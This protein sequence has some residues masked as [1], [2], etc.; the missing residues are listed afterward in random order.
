MIDLEPEQRETIHALL[1]TETGQK[2]LGDSYNHGW[3]DEAIDLAVASINEYL[4]LHRTT[5]NFNDFFDLCLEGTYV[6]YN[7]YGDVNCWFD[8]V[9]DVVMSSGS[10]FKTKEN[11]TRSD[12]LK[13]IKLK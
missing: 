6:F 5:I 8:K 4:A 3:V 9:Y 11:T 10:I 12:E 2:Y 13:F 1:S 7:P